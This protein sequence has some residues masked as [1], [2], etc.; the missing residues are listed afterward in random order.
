LRRK[1]GMRLY[2]KLA[3]RNL[4]RNKRRSFIA[5]TAIGIGL[6]A[7]IFTDAFI[8]GMEQ[9]MIASATDS[10]LGEGQI[11]LAG[12][13]ESYD[14]EKT[15][16]DQAQV[17]DQLQHD[18]VVSHFSRRV[19]SFAMITSPSNVSSVS[20]V[21]IDPD[22]EHYLSQIDEAITSGSYFSGDNKQDIVIGDKLADL[23]E[24][25]LG[26]RVVLTVAQAY[27]GDLS[28]EMFRISGIYH[29]DIQEMDQAMAF[30][31]LSQ[32][33]SM[34]GLGDRIHEIALR[35][36]NSKYGADASLPFWQRYS[37]NGNEAVGWPVLLPDLKAAFEL[38]SFA[39]WLV[40]LILFGVVALGIINTLFMSLYERMFEF[41]VLRAVGTRSSVMALLIIFEA[42][43]L[44]ALSVVLGIILGAVATLI[45][46]HVGI[47]Y[48]GIE[49]SG[50]TF[51]HLLYPVFEIKQY[52]I[53]PIVVFVFTILMGLYPAIFAA[54]MS[55]AKAMRRSF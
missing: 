2:L 34:L 32:A 43:A 42:G 51:R 39:T 48:I 53:Y 11:H 10:F 13:R 37:R 17:V 38:S 8:V 24:V 12:Y 41:G 28:Q 52:V 55:P 47:N 19:M 29:F 31:R 1:S 46:T 25:S 4:F 35:F 15:I 45:M 7:L 44:A 50:V 23:L 49:F 40:G 21:G 26:D 6:A 54:R 16:A 27:T 22:Q 30:V 14:V 18:P 9:N 5:G 3:V 33:Q 20:M 36:T